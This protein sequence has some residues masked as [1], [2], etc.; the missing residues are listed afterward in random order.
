MVRS[1][2]NLTT[3]PLSFWDYALESA[4]RILN[5]V[6]IKKVDKTPYEIW[7]GKAPNLSYLKVWGCEAYVK[8]DSAHK[9]HQ[10]S[11]KCIFVGYP[12][13]TMGYYF[14]FPPEN[15]VIVA[16]Y[17]NFLERDLISQKFSGRDNDLEDDHMDT[18]PF[19]NTSEIPVESESLGSSLELIPVRR[20]TRAP[21]R[22]CL[23]I[24]VED[25]EV[26]D[27][28]E[29]TNYKAAMLDPDNIIWQGAMGKEMNS[30]KV[31]KVWIVVD[32]PPNA[33][34]V[35]SK[36]L[37]NK[38]TNMDGKVHTYKTRLVAKGCTQTYGIDYEEIFF[39]VADIRAIRILIAITTYY[40]YEIWQMDV[41]TAFLNGRLDE[42]IYMEQPEGYVDPKYPNR[43][44]KLQR[45][46]YG[47]KQASRQWNKRFDEEIKKLGFIQNRD[48]PC[49]YRKASW[50]D[51]VF[52]ILYVDDILIMG[53]NIPRLKEVK[54]Y[55]GKCFSMKDLGEAA[56]I[57]GIKIYRDR[58][59][60]L[61]GLS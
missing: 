36:W 53:N 10:R 4:V 29:P 49:V 24:E 38:K 23:N 12:K 27:L 37:Y 1:M 35:R 17:G 47:L 54:D 50:S 28:R 19:E 43:V 52:L 42:D 7:L 48:E 31:M 57:L 33:K 46:I 25:D 2:F 51:V 61:I 26:G 41:K 20:T 18:L 15:K 59:R 3:L 14:Y 13:E 56:Y 39:P 45:S 34:V 21:N 32:L 16:R 6:P 30:M 40:D 55:L 5:M 9:L 60:R 58:S 8:R 11:V 22:L 44:C